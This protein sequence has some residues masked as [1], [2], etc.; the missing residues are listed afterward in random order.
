LRRQIT[1]LRTS[2]ERAWKEHEHM[3]T[4]L[5]AKSHE[6]EKIAREK[7]EVMKEH[8]KAEEESRTSIATLQDAVIRAEAV[9]SD[10][11]R[12]LARGQEQIELLHHQ[13]HPTVYL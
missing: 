3:Q 7:E 11:K 5:V 1:E 9:A 8:Q 13:V 2:A 6:A 4:Q 12:E 10:S